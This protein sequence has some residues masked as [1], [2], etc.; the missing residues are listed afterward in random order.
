M[1][2]CRLKDTKIDDID[3]LLRDYR[4][5]DVNK[6]LRD[7]RSSGVTDLVYTTTYDTS[8]GETSYID[9]GGN[10]ISQEQ[11]DVQVAARAAL[12]QIPEVTAEQILNEASD[13]DIDEPE[14]GSARSKAEDE[15]EDENT[16]D[17]NSEGKEAEEV[18]PSSKKRKITTS[19]L[20]KHLATSS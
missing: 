10:S 8:T 17:D 12:D 3:E 20:L 18:E 6:L 7:L 4:S 2:S 16:D 1:P 19:T 13:N 14:F 9:G 15:D 11:Y 5:N